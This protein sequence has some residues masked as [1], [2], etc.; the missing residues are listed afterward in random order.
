M[1]R[2]VL[3]LVV[4][5][6]YIYGGITKQAVKKDGTTTNEKNTLFA[7]AGLSNCIYSVRSRSAG[8]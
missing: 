4:E 6:F 8:N 1:S 7:F 2:L 5:V 3:V